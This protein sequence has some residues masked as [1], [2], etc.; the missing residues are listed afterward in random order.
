MRLLITAGPTREYLDP[1]RF[2]SNA[3]SGKL[4]FAIAAQAARRGHHVELIAGPVE[5]RAPKGVKVTRIVTSAE[6]F[7]A[8]VARFPKCDAAVMAAAVCDFRPAMVSSKKLQRRGR[9][10]TLALRPTKDICAHLGRRKGPRVVI[11][12]ALEDRRPKARAELKLRRK[13]CDAIVLNHPGNIG[14]ERAIV[15][16]LLYSQGWQPTIEATKL[17]VAARIVELAEQLL[18]M[19][20]MRKQQHGQHRKHARR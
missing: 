19:A 4:G 13:H 16:F 10:L 6:M 11:G 3:S 5:L 7:D 15:R 14:A 12:F 9:G 1:V 2:L 18:R 8:A 17:A 20:E